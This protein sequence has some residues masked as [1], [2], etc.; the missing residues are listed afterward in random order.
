MTL[1]RRDLAALPG[2]LDTID[3]W[4]ADGTL[5][6]ETPNRADLQI[7]PTLGLLMAMGDLRAIIA[8]RPAGQLADRLVSMPGS[9]PVGA[10]PAELL[11]A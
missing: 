7:A 1:A 6:A 11:P 10:I 3:A 2:Y 9:I 4:I 5:G 8:P